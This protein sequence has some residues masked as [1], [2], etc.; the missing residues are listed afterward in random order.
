[1]TDGRSAP[2]P[3]HHTLGRLDDEESLPTES[4]DLLDEGDMIGGRFS[5]VEK[6]QSGSF[7]QVFLAV[8]K[9]KEDL[10]VA[11]KVEKPRPKGK[12]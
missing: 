6:L 2:S 10:E 1:M 4:E 9:T 5:V 7:G 3:I 12:R 8:D 11:L